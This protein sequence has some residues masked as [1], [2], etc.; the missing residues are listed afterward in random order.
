MYH[1]A[2]NN[3]VKYTDP[4]GNVIQA[5]VVAVIKGA[6]I[7]AVTGAVSNAGVQ[8]VANMIHGQDFD[9]AV[10]NIDWKSVKSAAISGAITGGLSGGLSS[11]KAIKDVISVSKKAKVVMNA[12]TNMAGTTAGTM[13]DNAYHNKPLSKNLVRN[14]LIAG[15]AGCASSAISTTA[16]GNVVNRTGEKTSV[17]LETLDQGGNITS[18]TTKQPFDI[19]VDNFIKENAVS[20]SQAALSQ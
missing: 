12:S 7:G 8:V 15:A 5:I 3:P 16:A 20:I 18:I 19:A 13:V 14:N 2:A 17:W 11:V 6:V 4:D 10:D 9:T 1:Y